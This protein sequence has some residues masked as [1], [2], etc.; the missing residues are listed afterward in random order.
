MFKKHP[1]RDTMSKLS[2]EICS[3]LFFAT[4]ICAK[5]APQGDRL[6]RDVTAFA[7]CCDSR[8]TLFSIYPMVPFFF[9]KVRFIVKHTRAS[10]NRIYV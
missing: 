4:H 6:R 3:E 2:A 10:Y 7:V 1:L 9:F 8:H 5:K